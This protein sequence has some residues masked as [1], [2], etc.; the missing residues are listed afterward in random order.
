MAGYVL[1]DTNPNR[2]A[3]DDLGISV[4]DDY[5]RISPFDNQDTTQTVKSFENSL[6]RP[7]PPERTYKQ[8]PPKETNKSSRFETFKTARSQTKKINSDLVRK[9]NQDSGFNVG[10]FVTTARMTDSDF[11][12]LSNS[13][14]IADL[15]QSTTDMIKRNIVFYVDTKKHNPQSQKNIQLNLKNY[16]D[17][18]NNLIGDT[19]KQIMDCCDLNTNLFP[20]GKTEYSD[21]KINDNDVL[22]STGSGIDGIKPNIQIRQRQTGSCIVRGSSNE[23]IKNQFNGQSYS[24]DRCIYLNPDRQLAPIIFEELLKAAN[25]SDIPLNVD[26]VNKVASSTMSKRKK[27][28]ENRDYRVGTDSI[29]AYVAQKDADRF[30]ELISG[31]VG[32]HLDAF[33]GRQTLL[34]GH[35]VADGVAI[36]DRLK[37][38]SLTESR[39]RLIESVK[40]KAAESGKQGQELED[41]FLDLLKQEAENSGFNYNNLA[42]NRTVETQIA[43]IDAQSSYNETPNQPPPKT[44]KSSKP[45]KGATKAPESTKPAAVRRKSFDDFQTA[46][47]KQNKS[48]S[49]ISRFLTKKGK[50]FNIKSF[51]NCGQPT[52]LDKKTISQP[53]RISRLQQMYVNLISRNLVVNFDKKINPQQK[54]QI[55][56]RCGQY[57]KKQLADIETT[58]Q[59]IIDYHQNNSDSLPTSKIR[60]EDCLIDDIDVLDHNGGTIPGVRL[61]LRIKRRLLGGCSIVGYSNE[62][63]RQ[64]VA[65]KNQALDKRIYLNPNIEITPSIFE[66]LFQI[67]NK[68]QIPLEMEIQQRTE[69]LVEMGRN[70]ISKDLNTNGIVVSINKRYANNFLKKAIQIQQKHNLSFEG[71]KTNKLSYE[72]APGVSIAD[73]LA[74][75]IGL[76]IIERGRDLAYSYSKNPDKRTI[77][78][79]IQFIAQIEKVNS[80]NL[81]F[82]SN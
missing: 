9:I 65:G 3:G 24:L 49:L 82:E 71:R 35:R 32:K 16:F 51:I 33:D 22:D 60:Y 29:T 75:K 54:N 37:N 76:R 74:E 27:V 7:N 17:Q 1:T 73:S 21:F 8:L 15:H 41:L 25:K 58:K 23:M 53:D 19:K 43:K 14:Q 36:S 69:D 30:L 66:E 31:V 28:Y 45:N 64:E 18:L 50:N 47:G 78:K 62:Q 57:F 13:K 67:A 26:M 81:A 79:A 80:N 11:K 61:N 5:V 52:E 44:T 72:V 55:A 70:K 46:T 20:T 42:F 63:I 12:F 77:T 40:I 39:V 6:V 2:V 38:E 34:I 10:Q 68:E 48:L 56:E 4:T 59:A